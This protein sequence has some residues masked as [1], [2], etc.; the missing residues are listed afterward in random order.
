MAGAAVVRR[1]HRRSNRQWRAALLA[2]PAFV[3]PEKP[4]HYEKVYDQTFYPTGIL[5]GVP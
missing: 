4:L 3:V 2:N 1:N 5:G